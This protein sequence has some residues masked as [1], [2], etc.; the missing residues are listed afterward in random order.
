MTTFDTTVVGREFTGDPVEVSGER[1][2]AYA[3]AT[4]E[5]A[6]PALRGEVAP[7]AF[8]FTALRPPLRRALAAATPLYG[9]LKGLHGEHD[10][11]LLAPIEPGMRLTPVVEVVGLRQ[12][13]GGVAVVVHARTVADGGP[14]VSEQYATLY[15]PAAELGGPSHGREA[16]GH[17]LP[18]E[19]AATE[20]D[21]RVVQRVDLDQPARYAEA[22]GDTGRYHLDAD[23]ARRRGLPGIIVHGMCTMA[24][25]G[26]ALAQHAAGGDA[27]RMRRLAVRFAHPVRPGEELTTSIWRC[28]DGAYAFE[29]SVDGVAVL[30]HGRAEFA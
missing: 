4:N 2:A 27:R 8:A 19:L 20:P 22:S 15:F 6:A 30:R 18:G 23:F 24:F 16:P 29:T 10:L 26:R 5:E 14:A 7:P 25:A 13:G 21:A 17:R 28:G 12:R 9:E 3:A 1:I 11:R